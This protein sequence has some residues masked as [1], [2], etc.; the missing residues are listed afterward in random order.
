MRFSWWFCWIFFTWTKNKQTS[1]DCSDYVCVLAQPAA[2]WLDEIK[3][4]T[5][6]HAANGRIPPGKNKLHHMVEQGLFFFLF[7]FSCNIVQYLFLFKHFT[8][9]VPVW[10]NKS[11]SQTECSVKIMF[12]EF[13]FSFF[14]F[15][16]YRI[17]SLLK[18]PVHGLLKLHLS[19]WCF[20]IR[21]SAKANSII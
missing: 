4:Q 17:Y 8:D 21:C 12:C 7:H 15:F 2:Y 1:A 9:A 3:R 5:P 11:S 6:C 18:D 13:F 19:V 10:I 16:F 14:S 20:L